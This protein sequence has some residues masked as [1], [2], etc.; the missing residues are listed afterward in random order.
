MAEMT[1]QGGYRGL[2]IG[3][4]GSYGGVNNLASARGNATADFLKKLLSDPNFLQYM[5]QAGQELSTTGNVGAA[6]N[7]ASMIEAAQNQQATGELLQRI[8]SGE[9][10]PTPKGQAG[11][12]SVNVQQTADGTKLTI[13]EPSKENLNTYGTT[14]PLENQVGD[15][16]APFLK[17]LLS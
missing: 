16:R 6:L 5:G 14:V 3:N 8:L 4:P 15:N 2:G 1:G 11:P 12:D 17:A 13:S 10:K 9:F 7:P